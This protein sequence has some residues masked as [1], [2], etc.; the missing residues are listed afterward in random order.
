MT[1][2][3]AMSALGFSAPEQFYSW[4]VEA[5]EEQAEAATLVLWTLVE[6]ES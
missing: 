4:I 6:G 1:I 3:D 5:S 2:A